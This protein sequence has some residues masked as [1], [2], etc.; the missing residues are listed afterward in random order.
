MKKLCKD[1]NDYRID[2]DTCANTNTNCRFVHEYATCIDALG[3]EHGGKGDAENGICSK[4]RGAGRR[5]QEARVH[6]KK[7]VHAD[8][9]G[10]EEWKN[11]EI[12]AGLRKA[13]REGRYA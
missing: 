8:S 12:I 3:A 4:V 13:H 9:C 11:R 2:R 1:W 10:L 5:N 6:A 7:R